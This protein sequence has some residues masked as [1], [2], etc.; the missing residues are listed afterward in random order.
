MDN[1]KRRKYWRED[2]LNLIDYVILDQ[3][4]NPISRRMG[5]TLNVSEGGC[6]LE[7]HIPLEQGQTIRLTVALDEEMV[8]LEGRVAHVRQCKEMGY[9][10]GIEF[11]QM[12]PEG[13]RVIKKYIEALKASATPGLQE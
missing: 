8:E 3:D 2:S 12:D 13:K 11:L 7:T 9:C 6:L 10:S 4:G 1:L 5:R